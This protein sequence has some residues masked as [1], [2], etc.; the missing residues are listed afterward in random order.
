MVNKY[1]KFIRFGSW[2]PFDPNLCELKLT[3]I[4]NRQ[5]NYYVARY[6]RS[7]FM[8]IFLCRE[9]KSYGV[10]IVLDLDGF[11]PCF[12]FLCR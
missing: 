1:E 7:W 6:R 3:F 4:K 12:L 8:K 5:K 2:S 9:K 11:N 10:K